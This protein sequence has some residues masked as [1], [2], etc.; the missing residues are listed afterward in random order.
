MNPLVALATALGGYLI[1]SISF[2]RIITS[3]FSPGRSVPDKTAL[4][5]EG[6]DK[7]LIFTSISATSVSANVGARG[8]FLTFV[9]DVLKVFFPV[10]LLKHNFP[11]Q[12]YDLIAATTGVV[13]HIWPIYY[14]FR[15]G[16]GISSIYGGILAI[17]WLGVPVTSLGGLFLGL[18]ILRDLYF[19]YMAGLWLLIPWL[20]WRTRDPYVILYM[21]I[22]NILFTISALPETRQ[23]F[24][25]K[26]DRH[27]GDPMQ[28]WQASA[29]GRGIIKMAKKLGWVREKRE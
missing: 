13:G 6:S 19:T 15:G 10:M 23:W 18:V 1:G 8:G 26:K 22:V 14:H 4:E 5:I 11:G 12:P 27:W 9:L 21:L 29:M 20:W 28:A 25:L 7:K 24:H 2:A 3:L 17:D 16:R